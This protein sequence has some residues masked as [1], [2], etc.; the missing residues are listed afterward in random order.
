MP[1]VDRAAVKERA[2]RLRAR[3]EAARDAYLAAQE[4]RTHS[5]LMEKPRMGRTEGFA[6]VLFDADRPVGEVAS[7]RIR[8]AEAGRLRAA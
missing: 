4:G 7:A 5:V 1:Q 8:A 6:E 3:G 2:A